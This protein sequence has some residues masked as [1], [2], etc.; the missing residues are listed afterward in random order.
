MK[1]GERIL[2]AVAPRLA[3]GLIRGL[4]RLMR[5]EFRGREMIEE[6]AARGEHYILAFWH[7]QMLL[8]P[9]A[10]P[11]SR[12]SI[13]I[14]EHRDG[15]LISRTMQRLGFSVTRGSTTASGA[16][17]LRQ[18]VRLTRQGYDVAITPDGPRGPRHVAQR[19]VIELAR[20]SGLPI[21]PVAF[22]ASKK[23]A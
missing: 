4:R 17:A 3:T 16:R 14:S 8:M 11:G 18:L 10:Y 20:L 15:E 22:G 5:L 7:G 1:L 21:V 23:K 12:I 19:G 2:L 9:Y 6:M 13:L